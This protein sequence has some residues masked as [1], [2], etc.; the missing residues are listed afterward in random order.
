MEKALLGSKKRNPF[1]LPPFETQDA[2]KLAAATRIRATVTG[3]PCLL[4]ED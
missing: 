4:A 3:A 2:R 1:Q